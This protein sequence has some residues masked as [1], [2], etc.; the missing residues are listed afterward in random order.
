LLLQADGGFNK[1][2][3]I[4]GFGSEILAY[5]ERLISACQSL[6]FISYTS[7]LLSQMEAHLKKSKNEL[8]P[9]M[10]NLKNS[11]E[12]VY[13]KREGLK[14]SKEELSTR[15]A[16]LEASIKASSSTPPHL[17]LRLCLI[18]LTILVCT[19]LG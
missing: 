11:K 9:T 7:G 13:V 5:Y 18:E 6:R 16:S 2:G 12:E 14:A 19:C 10:V 15:I 4:Y 8:H 3:I 1:K 17:A